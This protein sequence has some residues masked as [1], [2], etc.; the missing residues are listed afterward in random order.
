MECKKK[1]FINRQLFELETYMRDSAHISSKPDTGHDRR[2]EKQSCQFHDSMSARRVDVRVL[3]SPLD[4][5]D[6]P[7]LVCLDKP[8]AKFAV[9]QQNNKK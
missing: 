4:R 9:S 3:D 1:R 2:E 6:E 5:A 8:A 7:S